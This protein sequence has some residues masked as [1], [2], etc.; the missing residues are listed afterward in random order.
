MRLALGGGGARVARVLALEAGGLALA[1]AVL[2]LALAGPLLARV[3]DIVPLYVQIP[4]SAARVPVLRAVLDPGV[5][6]VT[7]AMAVLGALALT[8]PGLISAV[9]RRSAAHGGRSHG[10][11]GIRWLVAAE[12]ALAT[13]LCLGAGLTTRSAGKLLGTDVGLEDEGLLTLWFGDAWGMTAPEMVSYYRQVVQAVEEVPGVTSAALIDYIPF[14][15]EDDFEGIEF[16]DRSL[17]PT[18]RVREEWRRVTEGVFETA[19][20]RMLEGRSFTSEDFEGIAP[21]RR[22]ERGVRAQALPGRRRPR[23]IPEHGQRPLPGPGD[24]RRRRRRAVPGPRVARAA[25]ALRPEPGRAARHRGDVRARGG[26]EPHGGGGAGARGDLVGGSVAAHRADLRHERRGGAV[27][28]DPP[29]RAYAGLR[30]GRAGAP[31]G[32]GGVF[33]V[34]AY[35]V[36]SR[37]AELGVRLALGA[38]PDRLAREVL[39]RAVPMV[40]LGL[41]TGLAAGYLAARGA[42]AVLYGVAPLDPLSLGVAVLAMAGAAIVATWVPARRIARI[43]PTAAI[44]SE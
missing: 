1:G 33:G 39:L 41:G 14:E 22:G 36:R 29:R 24:R 18:E 34:V 43:D 26:G 20:M 25:D 15:G 35:A 5:A 13:V 31:A 16:L 8:A 4:D 3:R 2:G 10:T 32:G 40:A 7:A 38:S 44:R 30:T 42:R 23:A 11:R 37:T 12:L 27:G 21:H 6:A 9:R 28:G 17:Q 19:G